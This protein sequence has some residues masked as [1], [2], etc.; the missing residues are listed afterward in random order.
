[1]GSALCGWR[2]DAL[3]MAGAAVVGLFEVD[4]ACSVRAEAGR[5]PV[6]VD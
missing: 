2:A 3:S 5:Q 1:M 6:V 4:E